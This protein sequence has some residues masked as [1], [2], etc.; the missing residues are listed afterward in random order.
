MRGQRHAVQP[1]EHG[2]RHVVDDFGGRSRKLAVLQGRADPSLLVRE[3]ICQSYVDYD[4]LL[5]AYYSADSGECF[6]PIT[7][8]EQRPLRLHV[9]G[10]RLHV[11]WRTHEHHEPPPLLVQQGRK[12]GRERRDR[13]RGSCGDEAAFASDA[14]DFGIATAAHMAFEVEGAP[15]RVDCASR[16][17]PRRSGSTPRCTS[18]NCE[19]VAERSH[20]RGSTGIPQERC[21]GVLSDGVAVLPERGIRLR[22]ARPVLRLPRL[23]D[24]GERTARR[25]LSIVAG[26]R[27]TRYAA[28]RL[29]HE[30]GSNRREALLSRNAAAGASAPTSAVGRAVDAALR[31]R[32]SRKHQKLA[33]PHRR[34][35]VQSRVSGGLMSG[36]Y[37]SIGLPAGTVLTEGICNSFYKDVG[38]GAYPNLAAVRPCFWDDVNF[39]TGAFFPDRD[40]RCRT[41]ALTSPPYDGACSPSPPPPFPPPTPPPSPLPPL[42]PPLAPRVETTCVLYSSTG[43]RRRR[44]RRLAGRS[45]VP[46]S[47]RRRYSHGGR[48]DPDLFNALVGPVFGGPRRC[49]RGVPSLGHQ[50]GQSL[51]RDRLLRGE[52]QGLLRK[53]RRKK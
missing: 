2:R 16:T 48:D 8:P 31:V 6:V 42:P 29:K 7:G 27:R 47:L 19:N 15:P 35:V 50:P 11:R 17:K 23:L 39:N 25:R 37:A 32:R 22:E 33:L 46:R 18:G 40:D 1:A 13:M 9:L 21:A 49:R 4:G 44:V 30:P 45:T 38:T 52:A 28:L 41:T 14:F 53:Q 51:H 12:L 36:N 34:S 5:G 26:S 3:I 43:R 24:A 20:T 10:T